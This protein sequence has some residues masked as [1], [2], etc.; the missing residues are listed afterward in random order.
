MSAGV[1]KQG[2][3]VMTTRILTPSDI[4]D[5]MRLKDSAGWNQTVQDWRNVMALAPEGCLGIEVDGAVVATTTAVCFGQE[6]GW[7]GM[8]LTDAAHRGRGYA[9]CLLQEALAQLTARRVR[10]IKLDATDMGR[11]LY[12]Q[13]GFRTE[14]LIERWL[15]P[16]R[17]A[18]PPRNAPGPFRLDRALDREA[19]GADR[20]E[21]LKVL[22]KIEAATI[23]GDAYAMGRPGSNARYF[24]PC[25]S[26]S[27]EHARDLLSSFLARYQQEPVYWDILSV[28]SE[29]VDLA[30]EHGFEK[31]RA[32]SRM[33]LSVVADGPR[34]DNRDELVF[35]AAGFEYG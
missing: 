28:N 27:S 5:C 4:P 24:G 10:W 33:S 16:P 7:I 31:V 21:L 9:R 2:R 25:V 6:L 22:A 13:L 1:R 34:L 15:R 17:A 35:A 8:V 12:E 26:R 11:P 32:L 18:P 19:F 20:S 14:G 23:N 30:R 29:A 3:G